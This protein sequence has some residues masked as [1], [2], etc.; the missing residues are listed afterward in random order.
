M[1]RRPPRS[2]RTDTIVP[3]ATLF[4]SVVSAS[5][6]AE[7][8]SRLTAYCAAT[9][10][11]TRLGVSIP[12]PLLSE[13]RICDVAEAVGLVELVVVIRKPLFALSQRATARRQYLGLFRLFARRHRP[14]PHPTSP[15]IILTG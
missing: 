2:T 1:I 7:S 12:E 13:V 10:D 3:Y 9:S 8:W 5:L 15:V 6:R 4:R 11:E 14:A